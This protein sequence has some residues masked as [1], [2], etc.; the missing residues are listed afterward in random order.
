MHDL[1]RYLARLTA[2]QLNILA[3]FLMS[4][5]R[6]AGL[7][8]DVVFSNFSFGSNRPPRVFNLDLHTSIIA[9]LKMGAAQLNVSVKN[10]SI[11]QGNK[12]F[13]K[14]LWVPDPV[15]VINSSS[16]DRLN[17]EMVER[18]TSHYSSFL[19][20]FDGFIVTHT[21]FFSQIYESLGK[22][23]LIVA[24][25]RYEWPLTQRPSSW[26]TFDRYLRASTDSGDLILA[27]NNLADSDYIKYYSGV[28]PSY[29][30]SLCD[31]TGQT[32][33][34]QI[35]HFLVIARST[36]LIEEVSKA[37]N[38]LWVDSKL[39]LGQHY[40]WSDLAKGKALFVVPYNVSTMTLFELAAM[41]VPV[42][43]PS[44]K[45]LKI[46][47]QKFVGVLSELSFM[48]MNLMDVKDLDDEN[49]NNYLSPSYLD[50]WIDRAD[51]YNPELMPN[52]YVIDQ[53]EE[54]NDIN[55]LFDNH[56][57]AKYQNV[58]SARNNVLQDQRQALL[59]S[60]IDK[61]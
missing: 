56:R 11:S 41:G 53:L 42:V 46:L 30:P 25:T 61:L 32:W 31:Y 3:K 37:T 4:S 52:I 7:R 35:C 15:R 54:L 33:D 26:E 45:L 49:P 5:I 44:G 34:G 14:F 21:P 50:W 39:V 58:I 24:G 6:G 36:Q 47:R 2:D 51:F 60:F 1:I 19:K 9:D 23:V 27:A 59:N 20:S 48:E 18:F 12:V 43:V 40:S 38:N 16:W 10:W 28:T 55:Q 29:V 13:R 57:S 22:P 17:P 8:R